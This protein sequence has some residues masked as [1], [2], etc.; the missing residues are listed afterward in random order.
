MFGEK[1]HPYSS[2]FAVDWVRW[3]PAPGPWPGRSA[4]GEAH[5]LEGAYLGE[6]RVIRVFRVAV[7]RYE[8]VSILAGESQLANARQLAGWTISTPSNRTEESGKLLVTPTEDTTRPGLETP[9]MIRETN[10]RPS[11]SRAAAIV[12]AVLLFGDPAPATAGAD[13]EGGDWRRPSSR[14]RRGCG[15]RATGRSDR[16]TASCTTSG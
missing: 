3:D 7:F 2:G 4:L 16:P 15:S 10:G 5:D 8:V 13:V 1:S 11:L 9:P 12:A 6:F 14:P